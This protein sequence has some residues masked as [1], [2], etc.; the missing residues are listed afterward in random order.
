MLHVEWSSGT[1]RIRH[2]VNARSIAIAG[3]PIASGPHSSTEKWWWPWSEM[4]RC[5]YYT[6]GLIKSCSYFTSSRASWLV[7]LRRSGVPEVCLPRSTQG[8]A[9]VK[10]DETSPSHNLSG[11]HP[12]L[13]APPSRTTTELIWALLV[14]GGSFLVCDG[15]LF[16]RWWSG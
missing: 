10:F 9:H 5:Y 7:N 1:C 2:N 15:W 8:N 13:T 16:P 14:G 6:G 4:R 3:W 11:H 12:Y